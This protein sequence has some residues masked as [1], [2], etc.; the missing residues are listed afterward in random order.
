MLKLTSNPNNVAAVEKFVGKICREYQI[1]REIYGNILIS[2]TEA[3]NNAIIHGNKNDESKT[4]R[5]QTHKAPDLIAFRV[6]DEGRG[7]DSNNLPDPTC[8]D[9]IAKC[10]GRGVFL[11]KQLSDRVDFYD[12]GRTVEMHF[13]I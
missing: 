5:I 9:N 8:P 2:L 13:K 10:G 6:S 3:V 12:N 4:V 1:Q 11:M 7:F